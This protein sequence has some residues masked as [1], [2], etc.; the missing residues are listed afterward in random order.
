MT[1]HGEFGILTRTSVIFPV[2]FDQA[3]DIIDDVTFI[4]AHLMIFV[5]SRRSRNSM[6]PLFIR[7]LPAVV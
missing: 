1:Y 7:Y 3:G 2:D 6:K 4:F 5:E